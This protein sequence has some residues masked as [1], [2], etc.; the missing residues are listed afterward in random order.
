M[1]EC[2]FLQTAFCNLSSLMIP[3]ALLHNIAV[4]SCASVLIVII[5]F[6]LSNKL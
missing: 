2:N 3:K 6:L 5:N 4:A 1:L